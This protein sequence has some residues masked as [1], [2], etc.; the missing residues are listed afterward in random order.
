M[1]ESRCA[2]CSKLIAGRP[3]LPAGVVTHGICDECAPLL[4]V[5]ATGELVAALVERLAGDARRAAQALGAAAGTLDQLA[6][7]VPR[8]RKAS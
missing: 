4:E 2:W 7:V 1:G 3:D 6:S 8:H 5:K